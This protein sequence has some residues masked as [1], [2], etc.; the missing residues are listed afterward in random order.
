MLAVDVLLQEAESKCQ[1]ENSRTF[2]SYPTMG[3]TEI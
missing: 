2:N 3:L 1:Y